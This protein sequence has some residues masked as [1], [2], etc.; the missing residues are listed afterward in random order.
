MEARA[1]GAWG[2]ELEL[3]RTPPWREQLIAE[4]DGR[5]L[6]F[7]QILDP[8]HEDTHYWGPVGENLRA[9]DLWIGDP[10][11]LGHGHG[12]TMMRLALERCFADPAVVAVLADPLASNTRAHHFFERLGFNM[13]EQRWFGDDDCCVYVLARPPRVVGA[14]G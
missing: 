8:A 14:S 3:A 7:L 6:G 5:P 12:T 1:N 4:V 11:D 10:A 13:V 9:I 2:D